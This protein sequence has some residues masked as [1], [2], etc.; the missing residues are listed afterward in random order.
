MH[1][2]TRF[3]HLLSNH[4]FSLKLLITSFFKSQRKHDFDPENFFRMDHLISN[5]LFW[6]FKLQINFE[7]LESFSCVRFFIVWLLYLNLNSDSLIPKL[8]FKTHRCHRWIQLQLYRHFCRLI[9]YVYCLMDN[10]FYSYNCM[11]Y[12]LFRCKNFVIPFLWLQIIFSILSM[13]L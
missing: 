9:F 13:Q 7:S 11:F 1:F 12:Q 6:T 3:N 2:D 8:T 4:S 10:C 5:S